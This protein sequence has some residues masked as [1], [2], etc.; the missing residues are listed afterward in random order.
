MFLIQYLALLKH[1]KWASSTVVTVLAYCAKDCSLAS[2][3]N[4]WLEACSLSTQQQIGTR[5]KHWGDKGSEE[6]S[7]PPYLT[8]PMAQDKCPL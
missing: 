1:T 6:R 7:W 8:M 3:W 5:W 4:H 2:T